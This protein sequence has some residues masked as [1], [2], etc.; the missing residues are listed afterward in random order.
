MSSHTS[1]HDHSRWNT[2]HRRMS[3]MLDKEARTRGLVSLVAGSRFDQ[4][5][6][7]A[8]AYMLPALGVTCERAY[9]STHTETH[10]RRLTR[11]N[12]SLT[13][14]RDTPIAHT[15]PLRIMLVIKESQ[16]HRGPQSSGGHLQGT[17]AAVPAPSTTYLR[18][19]AG[20]GN[21]L[22]IGSGVSRQSLAGPDFTGCPLDSRSRCQVQ[23]LRWLVGLV[24]LGRGHAKHLPGHRGARCPP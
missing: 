4:E 19:N 24:C 9:T 6:G 8:R 2:A 7:R 11:V 10:S 12:A 14:L 22:D 15:L 17:A 21:E 5:L 1:Q 3:L 16:P 13:G 23:C 20:H 18:A